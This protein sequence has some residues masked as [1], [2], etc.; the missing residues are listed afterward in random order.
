[1]QFT[2]LSKNAVAWS[3]DFDNDGMKDSTKQNPVT[4][5][6]NPGNYTVNLT[7][8]NGKDKDSKTASITVLQESS[9]SS[10]SGNSGSSGNSHSNSGK[11]RIVSNEVSNNTVNE[12]IDKKTETGTAIKAGNSTES[13][14][15][16]NGTQAANMEQTPEQRLSSNTSESKSTK[17]PCF[18]SA[19][20]ILCLLGVFFYRRR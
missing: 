8:S 19:S 1:V 6:S 13:I 17:A 14:E 9:S 5:Y 11:L 12:S 2:D 7:V 16:K 18:E 10:I 4:I 20:G 15:Q 3:W